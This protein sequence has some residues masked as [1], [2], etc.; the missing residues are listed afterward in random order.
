MKQVQPV[1]KAKAKGDH[2]PSQISRRPSISNLPDDFKN[3]SR[4]DQEK[5][6]A[7]SI[8]LRLFKATQ[9][10]CSYIRKSINVWK[11]LK[12]SFLNYFPNYLAI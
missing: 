5:Y 7:T 6:F 3:W 11:K 9:R 10:Q 1:D 4:N 2:A 8:T 12:V